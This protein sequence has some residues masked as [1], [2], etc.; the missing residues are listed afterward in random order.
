MRCRLS[1][2]I[3]AF[4]VAVLSLVGPSAVVAFSPQQVHVRP[5]ARSQ[6][7]SKN[8]ASSGASSI[9]RADTVLFAAKKPKGDGAKEGE[10][11]QVVDPLEL[12]ILFMTP[13][14]NPNSIFIYML[15][16]INI[17]GRMQESQ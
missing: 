15:L 2:V 5:L 6:A 11:K 1:Y 7:A 12:F 4:F 17:L 14:K 8:I 13:W 10:K 16:I 3:T 9:A